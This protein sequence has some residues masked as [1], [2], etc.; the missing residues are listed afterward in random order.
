MSNPTQS[1]SASAVDR[2]LRFLASYSLATV[3]FVALLIL[4]MLGTF[5]QLYMDIHDVKREYFSSAFV[6]HR[7]HANVPG[8]DMEPTGWW[9]PW[10]GGYPLMALLFVNILVGGL[11]RIRKNIRTIGVVIC[12][13]SILLLLA[14][15]FVTNHFVDE[16]YMQIFEEGEKNYFVDYTK[17]DVEVI[18]QTGEGKHAKVFTIPHEKLAPLDRSSGSRRTFSSPAWPFAITVSHYRRNSA[19]VAGEGEVAVDGFGLS[20]VPDAKK[21]EQNV[22]GALVEIATEGGDP[23]RGLLWGLSRAPLTV[24]D[25]DGERWSLKLTKRIYNLPFTIRLRDF[26]KDDHPGIS[27][28]REFQ[29]EVTKIEGGKSDDVKIWMNHPMHA[30]VYTLY[31]AGWGPQEGEPAGTPDYTVLA[32][33]KRP[34]FSGWWPLASVC[35]VSLGLL[36]HFIMKL[37]GHFERE[38][39]R[40]ARKAAAAESQPAAP[41]P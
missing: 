30:G 4:V 32:V 29:S 3:L 18:K 1:P 6:V 25:A 11:I 10:V 12:H 35:I 14:W 20:R 33:W 38:A 15:G 28:A 9:M 5:A 40:A 2:V 8:G 34:L 21:A 39:A 37:V 31:Q 27:M 36:T 22:P 23:Q 19:V 24:T 41:A 7:F 16:G 17:W 26:I 13:F